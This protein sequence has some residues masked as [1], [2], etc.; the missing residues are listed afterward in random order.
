VVN[1]SLCIPIVVGPVNE[2]M[3]HV[4]VKGCLPGA[5][6]VVT[7]VGSQQAI[8]EG[9]AGGSGLDDF[10][11][12][13]GGALAAGTPLVSRQEWNGD[14]SADPPDSL[15][16][17]VA[18]APGVGDLGYL[19]SS[20]HFYGC[21]TQV[22][23]TG[24]Y[25]GATAQVEFGGMVQGS[26]AAEP[27]G[28][29]MSL[30]SGLPANGPVTLRQ[31]IPAG[32]GPA[33]TVITDVLPVPGGQHLPPPTVNLPLL[34]C[35]TS[36][37]VT[38]VYDGATVTL[39]RSGAAAETAGFDLAG[40]WF[41]LAKPLGKGE[42]VHAQ[43][44]FRHCE[45]LGD[46]GPDGVV[47]DAA[48]LPAPVVVEPLCV[49]AASVRVLNLSPGALVHLTVAGQAYTGLAAQGANFADL[50]VGSLPAGKVSATQE[51]CGVTSP[52][53]NVA[54]VTN[55]PPVAPVKL[56]DELIA[57]GRAVHITNAHPGAVLQVW[58]EHNGTKGPIS[59]LSVVPA[60]DLIVPVTPF[61]R[62]GDE[63]WVEERGC[64]GST[65]TSPVSV[66][67][68][69]AAA[70][71][72]DVATPAYSG[73]ASVTVKGVVPGALVEVYIAA[74]GTENWQFAG[75]MVAGSSAPTVNLARILHL[76]DLVRARQT[77]CANETEFGRVVTVVVPPPAVPVNV[78][79]ANGSTSIGTRPTFAWADGGAGTD[80]AA[81]GYEFQLLAASTTVIA[82]TATASTSWTPATDLGYH[83]KLT[84][85]VR[86]VNASGKSAFAQTVVTTKDEPAPVAPT[87]SSYDVNSK[88]LKGSGFLANHQVHVRLSM[89]GSSVANSYGQAVSDTRDVLGIQTQS[90]GSGAISAVIDPR[91]VLP[92]LILDDNYYQTGVATGEIMHWSANDGRAN[93]ADITGT[94]WSNTLNVTAP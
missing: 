49:G 60:A 35:Q 85:Q 65:S 58:A 29:R 73:A 54:T 43:Q 28:A 69:P 3:Q 40:L 4:R 86:A 8:A 57:C 91:N 25:P 46:P 19:G 2:L 94:L 59:G 33:A 12:G 30:N 88:T 1:V 11:L 17:V 72:P 39:T 9:Q 68:P 56:P 63:V 77:I 20:T 80:G 41:R 64:A 45:R 18:S 70:A 5:K 26:A 78:T 34:G 15:A 61:L 38:G 62:Q 16:V 74:A 84:F 44:D 13:G 31:V 32:A 67:Q 51:A 53:S 48:G 82:L 79:P 7:A 37:L 87:L 24:A 42:K 52:S 71:P 81:S 47:A 27:D 92:A 89:V 75:A 36:V 21:G 22:W 93:K 76:R 23:L 6:V 90:D 10:P 83:R 66:V 50:F 14:V 55:E